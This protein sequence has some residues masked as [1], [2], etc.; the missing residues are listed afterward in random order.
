MPAEV[1]SSPTGGRIERRALA[2][3]PPIEV[4]VPLD[5]Y[6]GTDICPL[7]VNLVS[8][9]HPNKAKD[10]QPP[11][12]VLITRRRHDIYGTLGHCGAL[13]QHPGTLELTA[14]GQWMHF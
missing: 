8:T 5:G 4:F 9:A 11:N 2:S 1:F 10:V 6:A 3:W 14:H 12:R 13:R 7:S